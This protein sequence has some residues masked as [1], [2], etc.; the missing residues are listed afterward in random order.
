[1]TAWL[2]AAL[3]RLPPRV[4]RIV[5]AVVALVLIGATITALTIAPSPGT[6][7]RSSRPAPRAPARQTAPGCRCELVQ[8]AAREPPV[9]GA[10][11]RL[12]LADR[13][14]IRTVT[15]PKRNESLPWLTLRS[16]TEGGEGP[17]HPFLG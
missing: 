14:P 15:E 13:L 12:V 7:A 2:I 11:H 4:R 9:Q 5:V 8:Q 1:M 6:G 17:A 16:E 3:E 10:D